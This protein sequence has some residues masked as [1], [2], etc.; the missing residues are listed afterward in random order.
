MKKYIFL[1]II[2]IASIMIVG[3]LG[4]NANKSNDAK[5]FKEEYEALNGKY[6]SK[7]NIYPNLEISK[8]NPIKYANADEI[9]RIIKKGTGVIYF[10]YPE[11]PWCRSSIP[12]L[13]KA[14][15]EA[16]IDTIYYMNLKD[17]RDIKTVNT[18]GEIKEEKAPT[19]DYLKLLDTLNDYLDDYI[20]EDVKGNEVNSNTKRIYVPMVIFV[21]DGK[22]I[23]IHNDTIE[24]QKDPYQQLTDKQEEELTLIYL[25]FMNKITGGYCD[26]NC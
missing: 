22:V 21:K 19:D 24:S 10:G 7:T 18:D 11:C 8:S 26:E 14:A 5:K 20:L 16:D 25:N 9:I 1:F 15:T 3:C 6:A 4:E 2:M 12:S 13:F 17:E 23:G